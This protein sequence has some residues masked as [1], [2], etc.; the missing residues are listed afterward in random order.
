MTLT[1]R[2]TLLATII[3][4]VLVTLGGIYLMWNIKK[5]VNLGLDLVGGTYITLEVEIDKVIQAE[6]IDVAQTLSKE[7]QEGNK[8]L[9]Q[10]TVK[11]NAIELTF[12]TSQGA[13]DAFI[14]ATAYNQRL[15]DSGSAKLLIV[16]EE[17]KKLMLSFTTQAIKAIRQE[18]IEGNMQVLRTRLDASGLAEVTIAAQGEKYI[19]VELPNVSD[20]EQAKARIGKTALLEFKPVYDEALTEEEL[21]ER[22]GGQLPEG[23]V[24]VPGKPDGGRNKVYLVPIYAEVT[25]R[26]LKDAHYSNNPEQVFRSGTPHTVAFTLK[27]EG[28]EKFY[29]LTKQNVGGR[30]AIIL[31]N[32]VITAPGVHDAIK[33]NGGKAEISGNRD[34]KEAQELA[35]L[36]KSGSFVAPV[37]FA[38]ERHIGPSLGKESIRKGLLSCLI[39]LGLLLLFSV[40]VY[41]VAGI[42][43]FVVLLYN[44]LLILF[45]LASFHATLTLP[46]IAGMVLTIGM[47][48]DASILIFERIKEELAQGVSMRKAVDV[49]FSGA[50]AVI[51]DANITTFHCESCIIL[52]WYRTNS[53]I[54]CNHDDWYIVDACYRA[55]AL[56]ITV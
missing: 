50:T 44:L 9:P 37:K 13:K 16:S 21:L 23:T 28:E 27:P 34:K 19:I 8:E 24:I 43:A 56:K 1:A 40:I 41:K 11:G 49:G 55:I 51:L 39:G 7:L 42:F 2:P 4:W 6:L 33:L 53:R 20:I 12:K 54:C 52:V 31:D 22:H 5:Y 36:L 17:E 35:L 3:V 25:G 45:G 30:I 18:A 15:K 48:I 32:V 10:S 46:G 26:L 29:E 14:A 38:E 47:A